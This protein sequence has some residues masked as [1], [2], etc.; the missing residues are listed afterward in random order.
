MLEKGVKLRVRF[1]RWRVAL[2]LG[3]CHAIGEA[4]S[5][6]HSHGMVQRCPAHERIFRA[7]RYEE[8]ARRNESVNFV[9]VATGLD[10]Y[11]VSA[12]ARIV[13][14]RKTGLGPLLRRVEAE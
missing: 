12:G 1:F 3:H 10:H 7:A 13:G 6:V 8:R 5:L 11:S 9:Q 2:A 14:G 4:E